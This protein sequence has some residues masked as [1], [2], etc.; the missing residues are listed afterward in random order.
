MLFFSGPETRSID[1]LWSRST[2]YWLLLI[3][4]HAPGRSWTLPGGSW[5]LPGRS[6]DAPDAPG[7]LLDALGTLLDAPGT[8][9]REEE[10]VHV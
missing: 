2:K 6:L 1:F 10:L 9:P 8:L 5:T 4:R 7:T 3:Q